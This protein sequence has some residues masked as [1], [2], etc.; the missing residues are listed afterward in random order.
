MRDTRQ[1]MP[2][3]SFRIPSYLLSLLPPTS[4]YTYHMWLVVSIVATS[5]FSTENPSV[6]PGSCDQPCASNSLPEVT[7][8]FV[9]NASF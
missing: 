7:L 3:L 6:W 1:I 8:H 5:S 4:R 2:R 9:T